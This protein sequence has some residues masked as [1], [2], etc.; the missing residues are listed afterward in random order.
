M[1]KFFSSIRLER[2]IGH[3]RVSFWQGGAKNG[4]LVL[5]KGTGDALL[6]IVQPHA[7]AVYVK[8]EGA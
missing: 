2:G 4:E 6:K 3:D 7:D 8:E 1:S 5:T